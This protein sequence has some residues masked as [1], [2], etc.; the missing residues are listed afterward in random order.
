MPTIF[1]HNSYATARK[2]LRTI[3]SCCQPPPGDNLAAWI[4]KYRVEPAANYINWRG[5]TV[6]QLREEAA[7]TRRYAGQKRTGAN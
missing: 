3:F 6:R 2:G 1:S 4:Q 7:L 5:R